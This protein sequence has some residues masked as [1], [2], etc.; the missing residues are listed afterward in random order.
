MHAYEIGEPNDLDGWRRV[1]RPSPVAAPGQVVVRVRAVSL[2]YRDILL[3][4]GAFRYPNT[5]PRTI[6][7]SDGAGDVVA[8]GVGV[9]NVEIGDRVAAIFAQ[10][11]QSGDQPSDANDAALGGSVDGML[12]QYVVLDQW[13]LVKLPDY[14]TYEEAATLPC[15]AV[16]AWNALYGLKP[17]LPGQTV[18]TL[19]TGGVSTFAIQFAH[20]AGARVIATSSS[21]EKLRHAREWGADE[22]INYRR[23]PRWQ[24]KVR[25][26]TAGR[27]VDHVVEVGG[28]G[29]LVQS[30]AATR[31]GGIVSLIGLLAGGQTIDPWIIA[32]AGAIVRGIMVGSR[33]TF[34]QMNTALAHH[35]LHPIID[36]TFGFDEAPSA[37]RHLRR[38]E[39]IGKI[40]VRID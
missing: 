30:I 35:E 6:P 19:G 5:T 39:H 21:D 38:G 40:V 1:E 33:A 32:G 15:A 28:A 34:L 22:T 11:W 14:L 16:T 24:D 37:L 29:T 12:A 10:K 9:S 3:A 13:G 25:L 2:N 8:L 27:G 23:E 18:L 20:A 17:I 7:V 4:S 36:R 26:L 31:P